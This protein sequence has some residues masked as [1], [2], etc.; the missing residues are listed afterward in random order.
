MTELGDR[1]WSKVDKTDGCWLWTG[2]NNGEGYGQI[3]VVR[4]YRAK[5]RAS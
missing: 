2:A 4:R 1:F 5:R 3:Y